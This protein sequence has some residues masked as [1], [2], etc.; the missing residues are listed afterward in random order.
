M[1]SSCSITN[2]QL[3]AQ[4]YNQF[5]FLCAHRNIYLTNGLYQNKPLVYFW[6]DRKPFRTGVIGVVSPAQ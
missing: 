2:G 6:K 5:P 1:G 3:T 4:C